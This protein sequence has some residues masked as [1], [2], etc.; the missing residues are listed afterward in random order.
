MKRFHVI[1]LITMRSETGT[2]EA[3]EETVFD[4]DSYDAAE[5]WIEAQEKP[6]DFDIVDNWEEVDDQVVDEEE[7]DDPSHFYIGLGSFENDDE[8][9]ISDDEEYDEDEDEEIHEEDYDIFN[10]N[11]DC[12]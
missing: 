12:C 4:S 8:D 3:G 11:D 1:Q 5:S 7:D 2:I 9:F 6:D 10:D